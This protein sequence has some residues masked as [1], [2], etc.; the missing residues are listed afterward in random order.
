[1]GGPVNE[2]QTGSADGTRGSNEA[3]GSKYGDSSGKSGG[4]RADEK[5]LTR[6]QKGEGR[7][8]PDHRDFRRRVPSLRFVAERSRML[9]DSALWD[10]SRLAHGLPA[11]KLSSVALPMTIANFVSARLPSARPLQTSR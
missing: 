2:K 11:T 4:S 1:M 3:G 6:R 5:P 8:T 9:L 10:S 7:V